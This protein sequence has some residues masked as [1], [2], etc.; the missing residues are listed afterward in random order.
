MDENQV[1]EPVSDQV[2]PDPQPENTAP[3]STPTDNSRIMAIVAYFI[4]FLP[5]L[6]DF[7]TGSWNISDIIYTRHWVVYRNACLDGTHDP[8]GFGYS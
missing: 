8:L 7:D 3:V 4:F 2:N 1:V 5:L 6:S